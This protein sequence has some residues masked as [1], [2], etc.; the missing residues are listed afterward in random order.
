MKD[1]Q[2]K[3]SSIKIVH[4]PEQ[5]GDWKDYYLAIYAGEIGEGE[6]EEAARKDLIKK[7]KYF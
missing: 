7:S 4:K 5:R 2:E 1:C 3:K 6:T